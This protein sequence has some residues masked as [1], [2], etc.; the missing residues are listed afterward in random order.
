[1]F[2][3]PALG[4]IA[5]MALSATW[6]TASFAGDDLD[7]TGKYTCTG[8]FPDGSAYTG[9]VEIE[10]RGQTYMLHWVINEGKENQEKHVGFAIRKGNL[11]ASSW[12]AEPKGG[13]GIT[14]Y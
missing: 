5:I 8:S 6:T 4:W 3:R 1:M 9:T 12:G 7:I 14:M 2:P 13:G 10:K 11:L